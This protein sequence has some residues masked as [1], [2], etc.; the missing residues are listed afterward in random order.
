MAD[1]SSYWHR[2]FTPRAAVVHVSPDFPRD[3]LPFVAQ[4][5]DAPPFAVTFGDLG[6]DSPDSAAG[7]LLA[8]FAVILFRHTLEEDLVIDTPQGKIRQSVDA[9][10]TFAQLSA[11]YREELA[12]AHAHADVPCT[13]DICTP[14]GFSST[15]TATAL[16]PNVRLGVYDI[17]FSCACFSY[18]LR[19]T[20]LTLFFSL[21]VRVP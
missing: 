16:T 12:N 3:V 15:L 20:L 21:L 1:R 2:K 6:L 10:M 14:I 4:K 18:P 19:L 8:S 9:S 7:A 17:V 13:V 11:C 5:L